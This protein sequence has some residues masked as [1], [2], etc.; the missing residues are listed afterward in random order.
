MQPDRGAAGVRPAVVS[1]A[2]GTAWAGFRLPN[3]VELPMRRFVLLSLALVVAPLAAQ[4][5]YK[6]P[7]QVIVDILDAPPLPAASVSPDRQW[8]L[9]F[10]Q[11]S[12]PTIAEMAQ[13]GLRLAGSRINPRTTRPQLPRAITRLPP[14]RVG[15]GTQRRISVPAPAAPSLVLLATPGEIGP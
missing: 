12:M 14:K 4:T 7:P 13:P 9:L 6:T 2:A 11:R 15:H 1:C 8:L 3:R 10:E 5:P